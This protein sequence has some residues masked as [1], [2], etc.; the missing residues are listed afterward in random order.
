MTVENISWQDIV[1]R[2]M[3]FNYMRAGQCCLLLLMLAAPAS[4]LPKAMLSMPKL[5]EKK[6]KK[7]KQGKHSDQ[8]SK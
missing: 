5:F 4:M 7:K 3:H 1:V 2:F 6:T 8:N